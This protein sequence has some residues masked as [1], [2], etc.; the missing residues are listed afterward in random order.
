MPVKLHLSEVSTSGSV[1]SWYLA[2]VNRKLMDWLPAAGLRPAWSC[3]RSSTAHSS[4]APGRFSFLLL[5]NGSARDLINAAWCSSPS[6]S[7]CQ[8][9]VRRAHA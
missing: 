6:C 4:V 7:W 9:I 5:R 2:S 8:S 3:S 1:Y